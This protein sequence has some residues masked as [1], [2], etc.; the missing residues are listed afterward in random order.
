MTRCASAGRRSA[1][2]ARSIRSSRACP[3]RCGRAGRRAPACS[4]ALRQSRPSHRGGPPSRAPDCPGGRSPCSAR[5]AQR[6][7]RSGAAARRGRDPQRLPAQPEHLARTDGPC[8][9]ASSEPDASARSRRARREVHRDDALADAALAAHH[10]DDPRGAGESACDAR[11][12]LLDAS[13]SSAGVSER[14]GFKF[15]S[16]CRRAAPAFL[17]RGAVDA[18]ARRLDRDARARAGPSG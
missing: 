6:A 17:E 9:S 13:N 5:R 14:C 1:P 2:G 16:S 3:M 18:V 8:R 10:R 4:S 7:G 11:A 15:S 12:H